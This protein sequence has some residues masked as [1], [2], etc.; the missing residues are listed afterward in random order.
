MM[1]LA[2]GVDYE[3]MS[4]QNLQ[5]ESSAAMKLVEEMASK[6]SNSA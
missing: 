3:N 5:A 2:S 4:Y 1:R 6:K